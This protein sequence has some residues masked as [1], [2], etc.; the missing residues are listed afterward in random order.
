MSQELAKEC[1]DHALP[2]GSGIEALR[3][4]LYATQAAVRRYRWPLYDTLQQV[5]DKIHD[6]QQYARQVGAPVHKPTRAQRKVESNAR[7]VRRR[8]EAGLCARCSRPRSP[9]SKRLCE[10]H[11]EQ[12]RR[13][14]REHVV[15]QL[16]KMRA[17]AEGRG[18]G[19]W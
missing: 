10:Y 2:Y 5:I 18:E 15:R 17:A 14:Q 19:L 12:N 6:A 13:R 8:L 3:I 16:A 11:L 7:L 9:R 4:V 1:V